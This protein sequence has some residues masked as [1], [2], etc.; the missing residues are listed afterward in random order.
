MLNTFGGICPFKNYIF[1]SFTFVSIFEIFV[2]VFYV[3]IEIVV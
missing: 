2:N 1:E 3:V